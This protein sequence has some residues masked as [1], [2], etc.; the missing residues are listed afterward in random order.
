MAKNK[1]KR[2]NNRKQT[3]RFFVFGLACILIITGVLVT[4]TKVW[5]E[6]YTKYQERQELE[7]KILTLKTDEEELVVDVE[8]LQDPEYIAR[9]L[10]EK[11]FYSKNG[12]Y[13]IRLPESK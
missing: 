12:E 3:L 7:Q 13:I 4:L 5:L 1:I 11:Y 6:I 2:K 10:R 8:K 9:Y